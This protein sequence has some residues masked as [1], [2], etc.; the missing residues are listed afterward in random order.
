MEVPNT[1]VP[2][3]GDS[4]NRA[5]RRITKRVV[6][7]IARRVAPGRKDLPL[8]T[9]HLYRDAA[10]ILCLGPVGLRDLMA[11]AGSPLHVV[12]AE[13]LVNNAARFT[14]RPPGASHSCEVFCSYK[15]SPIPGVLR[16]LHDR[17]LGAEVVSAYELW[18]ALR[19]GVD[20]QSIVYNGPAKSEQSVISALDAGIGLININSRP[21]I[22]RLASLARRRGRRPNVGIRVVVPGGVGG[23]L[24]EPIDTGAALKAFGEALRFP[25][26]RVVALHSHFNGP[27]ATAAQLEGFLSGLLGFADKL[28]DE[29]GL[30][31]DVLD[32]G[33]NLTCPTVSPLQSRAR[34]LAVTL[35]CEPRLR[36]PDSVL[37]IDE[38]VARVVQRVESHFAER[39]RP[40]PRIFVEPGRALTSNAQMLL[41][42]AMSIRD[43]DETG[44]RWAVLDVGIHAAEP[45]A[46]ELHQLF[47]VTSRYKAQT[48]LY[49][50]TGPSCM[51]SDQLYPAWRLPE[52]LPGDGLAI[53]D[54]GAYFVAFSAP[55]SFPRPAVVM[56]DGESERTLRSAETFEDLV[57]LDAIEEIEGP[58]RP[59]V[60]PLETSA[61]TVFRRSGTR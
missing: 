48:Q 58:R 16:F 29:F 8:A 13:T 14:A 59:T 11:R 2:N 25:D 61:P 24:G 46:T 49:R 7:A 32:V 42:S 60:L 40:V 20:P 23:Q 34:R 55:F 10:G 5:T 44:I 1:T 47:P 22:E 39:G 36:S 31:L 9:W 52:L 51:L 12:D 43:P 30:T 15:T 27:I 19:L 4:L 57:A 45:L 54:T 56:I 53:M 37:S 33:G 50:L 38:Y 35:G 26:L 17:G 41:C 21:E 6:A 3:K 18:L 28:H